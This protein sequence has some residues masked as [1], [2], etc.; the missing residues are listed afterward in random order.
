V[1]VA[2]DVERP[3]VVAGMVPEALALEDGSLISLP[4]L[5]T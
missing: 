5:R 1:Y 2:G 4:P 3:V